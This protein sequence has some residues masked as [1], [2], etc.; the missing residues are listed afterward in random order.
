M[1]DTSHGKFGYV[2]SNRMHDQASGDFD[3]VT[4]NT[5][6][7]NASAIIAGNEMTVSQK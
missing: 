6:R 5:M 1:H 4:S 7:G 2:K 3:G